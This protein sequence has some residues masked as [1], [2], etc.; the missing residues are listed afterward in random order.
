MKVRLQLNN[1]LWKAPERRA[2]LDQAVQQSGAELEG[3]I[4]QTMLPSTR[5]EQPS[6]RT[7]RKGPIVKRA[8]KALLKLGLRKQ[9]GRTDKV[10]AG[11]NFHRA[12]APGQAPAVDSGGLV[13]SIRAKKTGEMKSKVSSSKDYAAALD[14]GARPPSKRSGRRSKKRNGPVENFMGPHRGGMAARPF[15]K[16]TAEAFRPKFKGNISKAIAENS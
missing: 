2:I 4:K 15:F 8:T 10:I 7:Y 12:S 13:N 3:E 14:D 6:G 11:A 9:K 5:K 16:S 1:P